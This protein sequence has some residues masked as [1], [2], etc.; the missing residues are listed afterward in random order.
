MMY[1]PTQEPFP[2]RK[3]VVI[4]PSS[5]FS[6]TLWWSALILQAVL[7]GDTFFSS[8]TAVPWTSR[9]KG[10]EHLPGAYFVTGAW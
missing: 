4:R 8:S 10:I 1:T 2:A 7:R 5:F 3:S 9:N 6:L